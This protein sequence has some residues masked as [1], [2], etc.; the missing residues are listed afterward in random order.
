[1]RRFFVHVGARLKERI[2]HQAWTL[3]E[4]HTRI[5]FLLN[6]KKKE[7]TEQLVF[8]NKKALAAHH[9]A[10]E[11]M[12]SEIRDLKCQVHEQKEQLNL[13]E[14]VSRKRQAGKSAILGSPQTLEAFLQA[15]VEEFDQHIQR[16]TICL[17][18]TM[19]LAETNPAQARR[20]AA[21]VRR[22]IRPLPKPECLTAF[23]SYS[24]RTTVTEL[25]GADSAT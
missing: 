15:R 5:L 13:E 19:L 16:I 7:A 22:S 23:S 12:Q 1:M 2:L 18:R 3:W 6:T 9:N 10:K 17:D 20:S 11:Q 14:L 21:C 8:Q 24:T 4:T 25:S